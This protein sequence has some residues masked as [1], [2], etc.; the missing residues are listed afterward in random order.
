MT[1]FCS[2]YFAN[3]NQNFLK[4]FFGLIILIFVKILAF[5]LTLSHITKLNKKKNKFKKEIVDTEQA[6]VFTVR[7]KNTVATFTN[8]KKNKLKKIHKFCRKRL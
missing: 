5:T 2:L 8:Y 4:A 7:K 1:K 6:T 3:I